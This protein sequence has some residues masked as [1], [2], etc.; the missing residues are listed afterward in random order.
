[1]NTI[2]AL[3]HATMRWNARRVVNNLLLA[4]LHSKEVAGTLTSE[5]IRAYVNAIDEGIEID[6]LMDFIDYE[7]TKLELSE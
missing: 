6:K 5:D 3:R 4:S 7:I 1:M 2:A